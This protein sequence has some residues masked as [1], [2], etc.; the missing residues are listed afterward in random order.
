MTYFR[1]F[2]GNWWKI[3]ITA[4]FPDFS[5]VFFRM[6]RTVEKHLVYQCSQG[7]FS[8]VNFVFQKNPAAKVLNFSRRL[9]NQ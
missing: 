9:E 8:L 4:E 7:G 5:F 1:E 2:T 3:S 6:I